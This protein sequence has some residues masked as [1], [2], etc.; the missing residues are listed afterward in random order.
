M[1]RMLLDSVAPSGIGQA[2]KLTNWFDCALKV[3]Q[4]SDRRGVDEIT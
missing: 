3:Q 1:M 2:C 4:S